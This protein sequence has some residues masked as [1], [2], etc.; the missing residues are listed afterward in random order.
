ML[1]AATQPLTCRRDDFPIPGKMDV[2]RLVGPVARP[3]QIFT[4][5]VGTVTHMSP[6]VLRRKP[7]CHRLGFS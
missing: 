1:G 4:D 2:N 5:K 6:E 3:N 7:P